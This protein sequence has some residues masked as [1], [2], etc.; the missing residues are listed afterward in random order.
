MSALFTQAELLRSLV[1]FLLL[2]SIAGL[3]MG[4]LMLW[5]PSWFAR[6]SKLANSW[7]STRQMARPL[8]KAVNMDHWV[9]RYSLFSGG[10]LVAGAI[11]IV[12]MFVFKLTRIELL[13]TLA[14]LNVLQPAWHEPLLDTLVFIFVAGAILAL[15]VGLFLIFRPSMLRDMEVG[16]NEQVSMRTSLKPMEI[17]YNQ[18][19]GIVSRNIK[20]AGVVLIGASLYVLV[21]LVFWLA[22]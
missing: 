8:G 22:K 20:L 1:V 13:A 3:L 18:L 5:R 21:M 19:D 15:F 4:V 17:Q 10:L 11:Y 9:Y 14:G 7:V 12:A 2:G 16:A 6:L